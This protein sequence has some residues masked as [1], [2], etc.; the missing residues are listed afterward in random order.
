M[1]LLILGIFHVYAHQYSCQILFS[2]IYIFGIGLVDGEACERVWSILRHLIPSLRPS[3]GS[4]RRLILTCAA[5]Y[6]ALARDL[7]LPKSIRREF[8]NALLKIFNCRKELASYYAESDMTEEALKEQT[9]LMKSHFEK[10]C[11]EVIDIDDEI[12]DLFFSI[13]ALEKFYQGNQNA[14]RNCHLA[15]QELNYRAT[16]QL[17][18]GERVPLNIQMTVEDL[19]Q[20]RDARLKTANQSLSLWQNPDGT[21]TDHYHSRNKRR[22]LIKLFQLK[23]EIRDLLLER[24]CELEQLNQGGLGI[25]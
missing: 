5:L 20:R 16:L 25:I 13:D 11:S 24:R 1:S 15:M 9:E 17:L 22:P 23:N 21:F 7:N 19:V 14:E 4:V 6:N 12:C 3:H 8:K 10:P 2:P 18:T